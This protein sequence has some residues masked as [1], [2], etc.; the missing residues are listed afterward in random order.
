MGS[1]A[2]DLKFIKSNLLESVMPTPCTHIAVSAAVG[3][4]LRSA[5]VKSQKSGYFKLSCAVDFI[6]SC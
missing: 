3:R 6:Q 1:F 5:T 4:I 2:M